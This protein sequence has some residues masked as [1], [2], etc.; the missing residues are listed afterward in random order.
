VNAGGLLGSLGVRDS[1]LG[2]R[3]AACAGV[4]TRV[5]VHNR[6]LGRRGV[7]SAGVLLGGSSPVTGERRAQACLAARLLCGRDA[8]DHGAARER[9]MA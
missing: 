7:A 2:H 1:E 4:L 3:R 6:E 9:V 8:R 5:A